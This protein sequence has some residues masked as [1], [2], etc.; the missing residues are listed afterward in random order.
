[1][2]RTILETFRRTQGQHVAHRDRILRAL[3]L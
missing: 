3:G 2:A 1:L